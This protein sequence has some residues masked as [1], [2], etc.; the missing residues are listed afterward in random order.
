MKIQVIIGSVREGRI[1]KPVADWLQEQL[2]S[3]SDFELEVVD[4][5][6]WDLPMFAFA[7]SP[8]AGNYQDPLQVKWG[9]SVASADGY[10]F[11]CPEYNHG[12]SAVLKNALDWVY[13]EWNKKPV[14]FVSFGGVAGARAVE[15]VRGVAVELKMAPLRD[16]VHIKDVWGKMKDG[17]LQADAADLKQLGTCVDELVWWAS[18]LKIARDAK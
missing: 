16:A 14:A 1:S 12:Y 2:S 10:I 17:A 13:G 11:I 3:R 18:A 8:A 5:K 7:K 9:E 6:E 4:L 15:Q